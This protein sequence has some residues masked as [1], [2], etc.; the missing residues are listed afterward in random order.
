MKSNHHTAGKKRGVSS[1][2]FGRVCLLSGESKSVS[3]YEDPSCKKDTRQIY[4]PHE[5]KLNANT[6]DSK[7]SEESSVVPSPIMM[8]AHPYPASPSW[9]SPLGWVYRGAVL[10][11]WRVR[12]LSRP[13][14]SL[15]FLSNLHVFPSVKRE[16]IFQHYT[17]TAGNI[18]SMISVIH[19]VAPLLVTVLP[20]LLPLLLLLLL[21]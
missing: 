20:L 13:N 8:T 10:P 18:D 11:Y 16:K 5:R 6:H 2:F 3:R 15:Q 19:C 1:K 17:A 12:T 9:I 7:I 21:L 14:F 4:V